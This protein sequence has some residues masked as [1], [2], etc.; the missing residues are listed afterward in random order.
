MV[1]GRFALPAALAVAVGCLSAGP[2]SAAEA[3]TPST[4]PYAVLTNE[5]LAVVAD[6]WQALNQDERRWFFAEVRKR[7]VAD[8]GA[9]GIPIRSS[10]RFGQVVRAR[11]GDAAVVRIDPAEAEGQRRVRAAAARTDSRAYGF[12]FER[13]RGGQGEPTIPTRRAEPLPAAVPRPPAAVPRPASSGPVD[14]GR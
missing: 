8:D 2:A 13:R 7:L 3:R 6:R 5:Q 12:G 9:A 14:G 1:I 11:N 10:A 4:N